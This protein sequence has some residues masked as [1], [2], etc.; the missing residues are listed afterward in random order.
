MVWALYVGGA[1]PQR[2]VN[3]SSPVVGSC[4]LVS[5]PQPCDGARAAAWRTGAG[6][7][8]CVGQWIESGLKKQTDRQVEM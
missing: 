2:P 6:W 5:V 3:H 4:E 1:Y 8:H 7:V